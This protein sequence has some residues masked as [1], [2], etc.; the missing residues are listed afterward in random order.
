MPLSRSPASST[1]FLSCLIG[2]FGPSTEVVIAEGQDR[3]ISREM[4]RTLNRCYFPFTVVLKRTI[5]NK[6]ELAKVAS[7]TKAME[8]IN[9]KSTAYVCRR[10]TCSLPVTDI[11]NMLNL[12]E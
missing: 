7:F 12:I 5:G 11:Q 6:V 8:P 10:H 1:F 9:E 4:V 3:K 2:I